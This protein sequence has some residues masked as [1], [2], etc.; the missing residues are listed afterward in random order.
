METVSALIR[1]QTALDAALGD[2]RL[3]LG[4]VFEPYYENKQH[5]GTREEP[6]VDDDSES[7]GEEEKDPETGMRAISLFVCLPMQRCTGQAFAWLLFAVEAENMLRKL[8]HVY[9]DLNAGLP[10]AISATM[11]FGSVKENAPGDF[12]LFRCGVH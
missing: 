5:C 6:Q 8:K 10:F 3:F 7:E 12:V 9:D 4:R 1:A 2:S 11:E